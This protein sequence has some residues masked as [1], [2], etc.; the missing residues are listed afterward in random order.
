MEGALLCEHSV[1]TSWASEANVEATPIPAEAIYDPDLSN[2]LV[3]TV[4]PLR[5]YFL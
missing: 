1:I 5:E 2:Q 4:L 3:H